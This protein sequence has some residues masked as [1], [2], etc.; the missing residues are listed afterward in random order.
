MTLYNVC[1]HIH[2]VF[3]VSWIFPE[4]N[5]Q[6][7]SSQ[8]SLKNSDRYSYLLSEDMNNVYNTALWIKHFVIS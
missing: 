7:N 3:Y 4:N 1:V 2:V 6:W 8:N 5:I